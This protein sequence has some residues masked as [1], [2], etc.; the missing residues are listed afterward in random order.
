MVWE[1]TLGGGQGTLED[2]G[3]TVDWAATE[4]DAG[5]TTSP[6]QLLAAAE[7]GCYAMTLA[8]ALTRR[9]HPADR[10]TVSASCELDRADGADEHE[11]T[12]TSVTLD[13]EGTVPGLDEEAFAEL[14][15]HAD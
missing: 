10:L 4:S 8:L 1:G 9:G 14:A 3:Q 7:A 13:V 12:I 6:E 2:S 5:E 11:Y 15:R